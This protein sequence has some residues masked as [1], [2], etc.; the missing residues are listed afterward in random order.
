MLLMRYIT[1]KK[2]T[3]LSYEVRGQVNGSQFVAKKTFYEVTSLVKIINQLTIKFE[4]VIAYGYGD[5]KSKP[6]LIYKDY[7]LV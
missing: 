1:V 7:F 3:K 5:P 2:P 6:I 4:R